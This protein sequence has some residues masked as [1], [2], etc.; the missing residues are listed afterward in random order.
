MKG[1]MVDISIP[2]V[3][4]LLFMFL[5]GF[6]INIAYRE[7]KNIQICKELVIKYENLEMKFNDDGTLTCLVKIGKYWVNPINVPYNELIKCVD[8]SQQNPDKEFLLHDNVCKMKVEN[9]W[10]QVQ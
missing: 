4:F 9:L 8:V 3:L 7:N 1:K 5:V 2:F 10:I 6:G